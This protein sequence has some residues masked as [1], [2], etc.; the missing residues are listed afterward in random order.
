ML[1]TDIAMTPTAKEKKRRKYWRK[2]RKLPLRKRSRLWWREEGA[3]RLFGMAFIVALVVAL[4]LNFGAVALIAVPVAAG[5]V[6]AT[7]PEIHDP[8]RV[9]RPSAPKEAG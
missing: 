1:P 9:K 4:V 8:S 3:P 2:Q 5:W 6:R 7:W